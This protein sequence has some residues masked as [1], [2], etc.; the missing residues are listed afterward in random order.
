MNPWWLL[1]VGSLCLLIGA[2]VGHYT[3]AKDAE[4]EKVIAHREGVK[5]GFADGAAYQKNLAPD[6][7]WPPEPTRDPEAFERQR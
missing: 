3:A 6:A 1:V 5:T 4:R 7:A 2:A